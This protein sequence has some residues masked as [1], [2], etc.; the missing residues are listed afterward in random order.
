MGGRYTIEGLVG[1]GGMGV[2]YEARDTLV[3]EPVALKF[4]HPARLRSAKARQ[5]FIREAQIARRLRHEH[6]VAVHDVSSTSEGILFITMELLHGQSLRAYLRQRR[7]QR[8]H[9]GVRLAVRYTGQILDALANAHRM[10]FHRDIKPENVILLPGEVVKVLDFGLAKA[11]DVDAEEPAPEEPGDTR[12]K[13]VVGTLAYAAPEQRLHQDVD[14]RADLYA[15]GLIFRELLTL[16]T[17][18]EEPWDVERVRDDVS[19]SLLQVLRKAL[20]E[21]KRDRWQSADEFAR[22]MRE[23]YAHSYERTAAVI[24]DGAPDARA[25]STEGMVFMEGG[26]FLMGGE[27]DASESPEHEAFVAPFYI[28][29]YPVTNDEYRA[30][31]EATGHPAP[32]FWRHRNFSGGMQPVVGVTFADAMAYAAWAGKALP[33]EAEWEFAA[34]GK[35]NRKY[36]W[37]AQEPD[38]MLSNFGEFLGMPSIVTMHEEGATPEGV[39]DLAG[40]VYEWTSDSFAPYPTKAQAGKQGTPRR[41]CRGGA[42][43]SGPHELRCSARKGFFPET[44]ANH[45]G[46]RCVLAAEGEVEGG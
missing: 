38:S 23:A 5:R 46:F 14:H 11:V 6:I 29:R 17:P 21:N 40:N 8:R 24:G 44:Q 33:T 19:P 32:K 9:V 37:G 31:V 13:N 7:E 15:T 25:A 45:V 4:L 22:A 20:M 34:R 28:D 36:P 41:S 27:A 18:K 39:C 16:R 2:V 12:P 1:R 35:A 43:N 42:W 26:S 30:F 10:V 3:N